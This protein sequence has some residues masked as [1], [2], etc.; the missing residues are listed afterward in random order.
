MRSRARTTLCVAPLPLW[1]QK[2]GT[3]WEV[4]M[5]AWALIVI[6]A[7]LV[8]CGQPSGSNGEAAA[9][10]ASSAD[11]QRAFVDRCV[12]DLVAQNA[13]ARQW[14]PDQCA[15]DWQKVVAAGP[16][17]EAI[18][19]AAPASG[20][21]NASALQ[22]QLP[23]IRWNAR[24]E[25]TL[26]AQGRLDAADVQVDRQGPSLNF[27]WAETGGLSP[28]EIVGA[29]R[30]RGAEVTM[31]GCSQLGTGEFNKAYRVNASGHA[32]FMLSVYDRTAP[33]ANAESFYNVSAN[34]SGRVQTLAQLR[35]D[36]MEWTAACA[37]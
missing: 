25:G 14:A 29:L 20:A 30:A 8:A 7:A 33:T 4:A 31:L 16:M 35:S 1:A 3:V 10:G 6:T 18:L 5:R 36:G 34:L 32:P 9:Q 12:A 21:A 27:F 17:A 23:M 15:Q 11:A 26:V 24:P 13:Q 28:Y 22:G 2:I 37:Y 19:A